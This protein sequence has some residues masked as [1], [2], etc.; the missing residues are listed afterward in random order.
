[1]IPFFL[2]GFNFD[3]IV[4]IK[5]TK[6]QISHIGAVWEEKR[7]LRHKVGIEPRVTL[8]ALIFSV[9]LGYGESRNNFITAS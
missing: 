3:W 7:K 4:S 5:L 6:R 8:A 9:D 2:L 1:M